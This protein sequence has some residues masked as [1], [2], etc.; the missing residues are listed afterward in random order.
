[1]T[2][3]SGYGLTNPYADPVDGSVPREADPRARRPR[4]RRLVASLGVVSLGLAGVG[5]AAA[6][7]AA[8]GTPGTSGASRADP[9][10]GNR[11]PLVRDTVRPPTLNWTLPQTTDGTVHVG[12]QNL[13]PAY[14]RALDQAVHQYNRAGIGVT[15]RRTTDPNQLRYAQIMVV[16]AIDADPDYYGAG[17]CDSGVAADRPE[18]EGRALD[19]DYA[20]VELYNDPGSL[21][22]NGLVALVAHELGHALGLRH[23][24]DVR[25]VMFAGRDAARRDAVGPD[26]LPVVIGADGRVRQVFLTPA[27]IALLRSYYAR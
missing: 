9:G 13:S 27:E 21:T 5:V 19:C 8:A 14:G 7:T 6:G 4:Y 1:M 24:N 20:T 12:T 3:Q 25:S 23:T 18:Q 22:P 26:R 10:V 11:T 2:Q 17:W 16:E 15:L